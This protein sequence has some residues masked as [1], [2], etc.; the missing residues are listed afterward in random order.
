[1]PARYN[2]SARGEVSGC[3]EGTRV[4]ILQTLRDW[5][6]SSEKTR[7]QILWLKGQAGSGKSAIAH[8]ISED[9]AASGH[10]GASF[11]FSQDQADRADGLR[12]FPTI[13][14]QLAYSVPGFRSRLLMALQDDQEAHD[15]DL[16]TQLRNLILV[17][18]QGDKGDAQSP[19]VIVLDALNECGTSSHATDIITCLAALASKLPDW[20]RLRI[21]ITSR[22]EPNLEATMHAIGLHKTTSSQ[23]IG[24][25]GGKSAVKPQAAKSAFPMKLEVA[26]LDEV[27]PNLVK[28]DIRL[29]LKSCLQSKKHSTTDVDIERLVEITQ[30][31]FIVASTAVR[32]IDDSLASNPE[33]W[34]NQL[35]V[36]LSLGAHHKN[37]TL[38]TVGALDPTSGTLPP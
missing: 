20:L 7:L 1:M 36:L 13:A 18:L 25:A 8:T 15:S 30:G 32:F 9:C 14:Y 3:Q 29:Y 27:Q 11:F 19:I 38:R 6:F 5:I 16:S 17:P 37:R 31:L 10:L 2:S 22:S 34:K 33:G 28:E 26:S 21:L 24:K 12:V 35:E 23:S 4:A